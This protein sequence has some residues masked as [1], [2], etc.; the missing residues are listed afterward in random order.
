MVILF[1]SPHENGYTK[2]LTDLL[3]ENLKTKFSVAYFNAYKRNI[4]PCVDCSVCKGTSQCAFTDILDLTADLAGCDVIVI[5]SPIYNL[6]FP[7]PLKALFD[8]F[9]LYY[10]LHEKNEKWRNINKK[11]TVVLLTSGR[12]ANSYL[13]VI[14]KQLNCIL[15]YLNANITFEVIWDNTDNVTQMGESVVNEVKK[16]A[17]LL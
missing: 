16:I 15:P 4:H 14:N 9:Q 8:R 10:N 6:S 12:Q 5:A 2:K 3:I 13:D 17:S 7:A 11:E 1:G